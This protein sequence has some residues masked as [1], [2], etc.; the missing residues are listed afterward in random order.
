[1]TWNHDGNRVQTYCV[2]YGP[3]SCAVLTQLGEV[4][5]ADEPD[6]IVF[7]VCQVE[8]LSPDLLLEFCSEEQEIVP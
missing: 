8:K 1:M 4:C 3:H 7:L 5:V 6:G 2:G